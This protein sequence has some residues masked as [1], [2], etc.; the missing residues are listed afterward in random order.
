MHLEVDDF[1][2][3][4]K[5]RKH[6]PSYSL[7]AVVISALSELIKAM[8]HRGRW[9]ILWQLGLPRM[10]PNTGKYASKH[11]AGIPFHPYCLA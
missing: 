1:V 8:S 2:A 4:F 11:G 10:V 3:G 7:E 9:D 6:C 5:L